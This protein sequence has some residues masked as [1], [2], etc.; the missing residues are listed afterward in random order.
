MRLRCLAVLAV[1]AMPYM[2]TVD[3]QDTPRTQRL[4]S[5]RE[6]L[7]AIHEFE[8]GLT[9]SDK[10]IFSGGA[11]NLFALAKT[12]AS[13]EGRFGE[14]DVNERALRGRHNAESA[15]VA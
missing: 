9:E 4:A 3:A 12:F 2:A 10:R 7:A 11:Q 5:L 15:E 6:N 8:E 1:G 14:D 13:L